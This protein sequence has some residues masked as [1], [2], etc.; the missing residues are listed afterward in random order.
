M[1]FVSVKTLMTSTPNRN[2]INHELNVISNTENFAKKNVKSNRIIQARMLHYFMS[3]L[4]LQVL[5]GSCRKEDE[6]KRLK[7]ILRHTLVALRFR[8]HNTM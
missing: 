3:P 7:K 4:Q 2:S 5:H 8:T 6:S 1:L